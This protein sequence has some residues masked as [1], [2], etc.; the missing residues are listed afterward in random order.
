MLKSELILPRLKKRGNEIE[1]LW[2]ATDYNYLQIAAELI[3]I[4]KAHVGLSRGELEVA[5]RQYEGDSLDYRIIRGLAQVLINRCIFSS[6]TQINP[7]EITPNIPTCPNRVIQLTSL[8]KLAAFFGT[9]T[10]K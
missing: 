2:L 10:K 4:V 5:L 9:S 1:P 7:K 3:Q 8:M 6:D